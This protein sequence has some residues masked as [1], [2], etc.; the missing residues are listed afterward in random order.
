M[1]YRAPT[2][3]CELKLAVSEGG[4]VMTNRA[5]TGACELKLERIV[6][7]HVVDIAPPRGRVN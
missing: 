7:A 2:G 6:T 3:A 5:P 4:S 1:S